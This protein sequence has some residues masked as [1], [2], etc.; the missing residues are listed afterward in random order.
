MIEP[1]FPAS[2]LGS[3]KC[4]NMWVYGFQNGWT[5]WAMDH[6]SSRKTWL[7]KPFY[8]TF[9][10]PSDL[11]RHDDMGSYYYYYNPCNHIRSSQKM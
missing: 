9:F 7:L 1:R 8:F 2:V 11:T 6:S 4:L 3:F 5:Y 10:T